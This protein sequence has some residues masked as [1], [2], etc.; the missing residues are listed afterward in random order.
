MSAY[1]PAR[2]G[3]PITWV[4]RD[5]LR[6]WAGRQLD[7]KAHCAAPSHKKCLWGA[8]APLAALLLWWAQLLAAW[9]M[10]LGQHARCALHG[11]AASFQHGLVAGLTAPE[12]GCS[13]A[14]EEAPVDFE[15]RVRL[16]AHKRSAL[17]H[18]SAA[19]KRGELDAPLLLRAGL[20]VR[21]AR[22][23]HPSPGSGSRGVA[24][25]AP[26]VDAR[27]ALQVA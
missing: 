14:L 25:V 24:R 8:Q 2:H 20:A 22:P 16:L 21:L 26:M 15:P 18:V 1:I 13:G 19:V 5:P 12:A 3:C 23:R 9:G 27:L 11:G 4:S 17:H 7:L 6:A 10:W